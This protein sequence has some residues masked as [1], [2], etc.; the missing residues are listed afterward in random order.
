MKIKKAVYSVFTIKIVLFYLAITWGM[1]I[2]F[3]IFNIGNIQDR[4]LSAGLEIPYF[5]FH[6]FAQSSPTEV[7]QWLLLIASVLLCGVICGKASS[8]NEKSVALFFLLIGLGLS[9]MVLE[10]AGNIRHITTRYTDMIFGFTE[11]RN[12]VRII[13]EFIIYGLLG[14][15]MV[16]PLVKYGKS[17]GFKKTTKYYLA[18]GYLA[19]ATASVASASRYI[20]DWYDRFGARILYLVNIDRFDTWHVAVSNLEDLNTHA[21]HMGFYFMDYAVEE[22]I[23]LIGAGFLLASLLSFYESY[24]EKSSLI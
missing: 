10:D 12:I 2:I 18:I 14:G 22:S 24:K 21:T 6:L 9:I 19:Y 3:D 11:R 16:Y 23:E 5:F 1:V 4:L 15:L 8:K 20:G 17:I 7:F 13:V